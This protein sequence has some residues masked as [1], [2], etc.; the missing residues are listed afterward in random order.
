MLILSELSSAPCRVEW[1]SVFVQLQFSMVKGILGKQAS[2]RCW[3]RVT[4]S[5]CFNV[6][7]PVS[8][9][10][11]A[12]FWVDFSG[13]PWSELRRCSSFLYWS[14]FFLHSYQCRSKPGGISSSSQSDE[15]KLK[16]K[17]WMTVI[18][19]CWGWWIPSSDVSELADYV[20]ASWYESCW[21]SHFMRDVSSDVNGNTS[22]YIRLLLSHPDISS[23]SSYRVETH[24]ASVSLSL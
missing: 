3:W 17:A 2:C 12:A 7:L 8:S 16:G 21:S 22:A 14:W 24:L 10:S 11:L 15:V 1:L 9:Q 6:N 20:S 19:H 5:R 13:M 18:V 4:G 23:D